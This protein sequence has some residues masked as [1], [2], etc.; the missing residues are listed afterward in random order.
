M[1]G[2]TMRVS[3]RALTLKHSLWLCRFV[4]LLDCARISGSDQYAYYIV[5]YKAVRLLC[6]DCSLHTYA[7]LWV[8]DYQQWGALRPAAVC[9]C[10]ELL[11]YN[12][13]EVTVCM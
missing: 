1:I 4:L 3:M 2:M 5:Q 12:L 7:E 11:C 6:N 9:R 13:Q 10:R 8:T